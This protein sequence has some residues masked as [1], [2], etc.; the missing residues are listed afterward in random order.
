[1]AA[2]EEDGRNNMYMKISI[3]KLA[4]EMKLPTDDLE[5]QYRKVWRRAWWRS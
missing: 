4:I 2:R 1:M 3:S 5:E